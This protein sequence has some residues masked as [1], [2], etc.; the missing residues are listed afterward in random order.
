MKSF[1]LSVAVLSTLL[2]AVISTSDG[3][4]RPVRVRPS[5][6]QVSGSVFYEAKFDKGPGAEETSRI[7]L[8]D[9]E[10]VLH[11]QTSGA[12]SAPVTTDFFGRYRFPH[13]SPGTYQLRWK[14][15]RG[16]AAGAHPDQIVIDSGPRFPVPAQLRPDERTGVIVG[17]VT[18]GDA[19][20]PWSYDELFR[21][22]HTATVTV[23]NAARTDTL[24][25]PVH[26][27]AEG[28]YAVAG[29]PRSQPTTIRVQ[30]QAATIT[31]ALGPNAISVGN[32]V[33]STDLQLANRRPEIVTMIPQAGGSLIK[34][35]APG[36]TIAIVV[37]SR[38]LDNDALQYEW[39]TATGHGTVAAAAPGTANWTLPSQPGTYSAY[40]QVG[41]GRGG[42]ARHRIDFTSARTS[43]R[44]SGT[45]VRK[46]DGAPVAG[47]EVVV[48]GQTAKT[49]G[50]GF[51]S[52]NAPL[53]DRYVMTIDRV[54]FATFSRVVDSGLTGQTWP[55]V[56]TQSQTVDPTQ[57]IDLVDGRPELERKKRK[58]ARIRVPANALVGP[59]GA[60]PTGPLTAHIA[61]LL[62]DEGEAPGD[63]GA[64][65]GGKEMNL[66]SYGA[67]FV[68]FRDAAGT[69]YNLRPGTQADVE[70][71]A[72]PSMVSGAPSKVRLWSYDTAD[73][74]WKESGTSSLN[75]S[76]GS[77]VGKVS[78]FSTINTDLEKDNAAC[79][80]AL[81]YPPIP[82]GVKLR[83]TDPTGAV[84]SQSF[85]FV[86]DAGINAVYRLPANTNVQLDLL[87]ANNTPYG[88]P[89]LLEEVPGVPLPGN[90]VNTGPPI[91]PGQTL[92]PPE[93]YETCKLVI[94]RE[95]NEPTALAFLAFKGAG[96]SALTQGYYAAVDPNN[97]RTTL[98]AWWNKNG[99][100]FD[101]NGLPTNG[102]RTSYLNN[103]DLGSGRDMHFLQR[104]DGTAAAYVTNYGLF[105]QDHGN[106]DLA[107]NRTNP[108]AT[109]CMEYSP[110]EGQGTTRVVKFFVYNGAGGGANAPRVEF[111]DLDGFGPKFVP[112]LCN[113]CHG[114]SYFPANAAAPTFAEINMGA[115]FREL[116]IATYKFPGGRLVANNAEKDAFRAQNLIVK[117]AA[118]A[119]T[120][121]LQGI[122]DLITGWYAGGT[123]DQDNNFTPPG[124]AGAPQQQLY[125]DV[126]KH[127]CRTCHVGLDGSAA[128][129]GIGWISYEQLRL[130][131]GLLDS[132]V[133]CD[134][135]VMPHAVITYRNFWLSAS[136]HRPAA[137]RTF[138][139]GAGW[140]AIGPCN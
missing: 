74:Y 90:V 136:P 132:F 75:G 124:W 76:A 33:A 113:N 88:A 14:T 68:E 115:A 112:N 82:T 56:S 36:A 35:A 60:P 15:Q 85:E 140:P 95:A 45:V 126:V 97:E 66:I 38:D 18:L 11:N 100:T 125:H 139:N 102:V 84:F 89:V 51:F 101:A 129:S 114:G 111:A 94:L 80:K 31:R 116:D 73:G 16:W 25:G 22:N 62:I 27:N 40:V 127:S 43:E 70:M 91:P 46:Q 122:K 96:S 83:V 57:V 107:A 8:P 44:F 109:V 61:T 120:I 53:N 28:R 130:R 138:A 52:V 24:S 123:N 67:A 86:L 12:D 5:G 103:N 69:K 54:G 131:Q 121:S 87:N 104:P 30:S 9:I 32:A 26:T 118:P 37:G 34:T 78:H 41:D 20:T 42:W 1:P 135:R 108:G 7:A 21:V 19:G 134:G 117:G 72:P 133:L 10:V 13:Q 50:N 2:I 63:W 29:L 77:F 110:V 58:G 6:G 105:N 93:P 3:C 137:L 17:H 99:F 98:G 128:N 65:L 4:R 92:W 71:F 55:L 59:G 49:D 106:A 47:A 48:N 23:L 79:L 64:M 39:A 119:D 81:I